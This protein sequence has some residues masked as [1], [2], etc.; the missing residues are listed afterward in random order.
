MTL[1]WIEDAKRKAILKAIEPIKTG[2]IIGL[3][4]G[5]TIAYAVKE[6]ARLRRDRKFDI[7]IVPSSYQIEQLSI[8]NG[9]PIMSLNEAVSIDYTI[10]GAD[11]VQQ[12]TLHLVKGGGGA[13]LQ[14]KLVDVAAH[15]LAIAV[16]QSKLSKHL[17]GK[18]SIPLEVYPPAYRYVMSVI[19]KMGGRAR[20]REGGGKVGPVITDN[21][22]VLLDADF[23]IIRDPAS[24]ERR[25]KAI[26][27]ILETGLFLKLAKR[28]YVGLRNGEVKI[29]KHR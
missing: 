19:A 21:G 11:Q 25:L 13:L 10:D 9:L 6:L 20:L 17:G 1:P 18:Q 26:P 3:G 27:G 16:D 14:E 23:G 4:S 15:D 28:V 8:Q 7:S 5:S 29:L 2:W 12:G 22:D 24:L